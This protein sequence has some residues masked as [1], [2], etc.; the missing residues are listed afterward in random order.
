LVDA[1][2]SRLVKDDHQEGDG[3]GTA[4]DGAQA[5]P[6]EPTGDPADNGGGNECDFL[7]A[8]RARRCALAISER[9]LDSTEAVGACAFHGLEQYRRLR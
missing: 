2:P 6:I 9:E 3:S 1:F 4:Q 8:V 7:S 5:L